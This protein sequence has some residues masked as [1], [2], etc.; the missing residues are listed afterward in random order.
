MRMTFK[1]VLYATNWDEVLKELD[2]QYF[3]FEPEYRELKTEFERVY[4]ELKILTPNTNNEDNFFL[5][6]EIVEEVVSEEQETETWM[7]VS[8]SIANDKTSYAVEFSP[9]EDWL[10]WYIE[11]P[12]TQITDAEIVAHC[13]WEMTWAGFEQEVIQAKFRD[14]KDM[15]KNAEEELREYLDSH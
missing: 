15:A 13:L 6:F 2:K 4:N 12:A 3:D 11:F 5:K 1:D 7:H 8:G 14:I 9:W 10:G